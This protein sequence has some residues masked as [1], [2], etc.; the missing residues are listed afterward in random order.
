MLACSEPLRPLPRGV[1][2]AQH[3][4]SVAQHPV[5]D[6]KRRSGDD[7]LAGT[8]HA[9]GS[10]HPRVPDQILGGLSD[11]GRYGQGGLWVIVGNIGDRLIQIE[12]SQCGPS[13]LQRPLPI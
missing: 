7:K 1:E 10:S 12:E 8:R 2:Y 13:N 6:D 11:P 5:R 3:V 9:P 4:H